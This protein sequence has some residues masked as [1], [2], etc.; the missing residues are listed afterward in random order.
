MI[1]IFAHPESHFSDLDA[2][3]LYL[4]L[5]HLP[6]IA[7]KVN[8]IKIQVRLQQ[9]FKFWGPF[10]FFFGNFS[11]SHKNTRYVVG[12]HKSCLAQARQHLWDSTTYL[13]LCREMK[14]K[15]INF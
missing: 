1:T 8:F 2:I 9:G 3:T 13:F 14:N 7:T 12:S 10:F 4:T 5:L 15:K 6:V 11:S